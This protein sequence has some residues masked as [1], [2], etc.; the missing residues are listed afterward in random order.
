MIF[1]TPLFFQRY[2]LGE[3]RTHAHPKRRQAKKRGPSRPCA[4]PSTASSSPAAKSSGFLPTW[5]ESAIQR[6]TGRGGY[7]LNT[8]MPCLDKMHAQ[9]VQFVPEAKRADTA[10]INGALFCPNHGS[11]PRIH[12]SNGIFVVVVGEVVYATCS[13]KSCYKQP[14]SPSASGDSIEVVTG[15]EKCWRPW[16]KFTEESYSELEKK[17]G[18]H[19][20]GGSTSRKQG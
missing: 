6:V 8:S 1:A 11:E 2:G 5:M 7:A 9:L 19:G 16:F 18:H 12:S 17:M 10:H 15:T 13:D 20:G 14:S 4:G 3:T